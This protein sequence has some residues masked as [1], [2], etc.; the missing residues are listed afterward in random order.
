MGRFWVLLYSVIACLVLVPVGCS[1]T[2][3]D[4]SPVASLG[5][6]SP[7]DGPPRQTE[8]EV[9]DDESDDL[10]RMSEKDDLSLQSSRNSE[11]NVLGGQD[12]GRNSQLSLPV[13]ESKTAFSDDDSRY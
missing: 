1:S 7:F 12:F 4:M 13:T 10:R 5:Q 8:P 6:L 9:L 3:S 2:S 11:K